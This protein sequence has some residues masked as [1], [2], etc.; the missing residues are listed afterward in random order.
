MAAV[1]NFHMHGLKKE[2]IIYTPLPLY[3]GAGN[4]LGETYIKHFS[5]F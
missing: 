5:S 2:D 3:H 1:G 4:M